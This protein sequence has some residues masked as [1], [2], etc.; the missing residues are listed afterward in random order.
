MEPQEYLI[1]KADV[2]QKADIII[3]VNK[4]TGA[5]SVFF[6]KSLLQI[7]AAGYEGKQGLRCMVARIPLDF[8]T[9]E[10]EMLAAACEVIKGSQDY[11]QS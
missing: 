2:I 3:G 9:D 10:P 8:G 5:E 4:A 7:I 6:G 11:E 1:Q